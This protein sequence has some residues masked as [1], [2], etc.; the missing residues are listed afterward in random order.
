MQRQQAEHE[1][2]QAAGAARIAGEGNEGRVQTVGMCSW[3]AAGGCLVWGQGTQAKQS[4][5]RCSIVRSLAAAA[6]KA[7]EELQAELD[8]RSARSA[9]LQ[10]AQ[11]KL[12][13]G[14]KAYSA[15]SG[16]LRRCF[17]IWQQCNAPS[18]TAM[19]LHV[20][21]LA[22]LLCRERLTS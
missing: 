18:F 6:L 19:P 7:A 16:C 17:N 21:C 20:P 5:T 12:Q 8:R 22:P 2:A 4:P 9:E 15:H 1:A 10:A 13:V 11:E 3:C 14:V